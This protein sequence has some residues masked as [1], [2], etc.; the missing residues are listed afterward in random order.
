[1]QRK[2][3]FFH[4]K[5]GLEHETFFTMF[6]VVLAVVVFLALMDYVVDVQKQTIFERNYIARD[7]AILINTLSAAP[8]DVSYTYL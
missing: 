5:K 1:M 2:R 8:G 4:N 6:D 3:G 7:T